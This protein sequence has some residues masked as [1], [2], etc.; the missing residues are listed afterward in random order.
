MVEFWGSR[1]DFP[2]PWKEP[3]ECRGRLSTKP[4]QM[5]KL[6]PCH[7]ATPGTGTRERAREEGRTGCVQGRVP[8]WRVRNEDPGRT[9]LLISLQPGQGQS[10]CEQQTDPGEGGKLGVWNHGNPSTEGSRRERG[11][12]L[13]CWGEILLMYASCVSPPP[14]PCLALCL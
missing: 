4:G 6:D 1:S 14:V 2:E 3:G 7:H 13:P 9:S 5:R 8:S 10:G 11:H 12:G